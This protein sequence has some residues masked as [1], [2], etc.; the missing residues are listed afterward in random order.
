M[1]HM[2]EIRASGAWGN[3]NPHLG[4][5]H[6][7]FEALPEALNPKPQALDPK[8]EIIRRPR[9]SKAQG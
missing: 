7:T 4:L 3:W 8:P 5:A 6:E 9:G 2:A 1:A